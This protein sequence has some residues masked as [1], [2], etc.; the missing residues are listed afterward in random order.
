MCSHLVVDAAVVVVVVAVAVVV[1]GDWVGFDYFRWKVVDRAEE[2][3]GVMRI[4]LLAAAKRNAVGQN[5][6]GRYSST[7]LSE[8]DEKLE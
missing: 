3:L 7:V 4:D 5:P 6:M 8:E 1:R 2:V